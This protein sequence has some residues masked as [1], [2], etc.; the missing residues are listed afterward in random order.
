LLPLLAAEEATAAKAGKWAGKTLSQTNLGKKNEPEAPEKPSNIALPP[1][2]KERGKPLMRALALRR[3]TRQFREDELPL[4]NISD[5]LWAAFG[6]NRPD[7]KRTMPTAMNKQNMVIYAAMNSGIWRYLPQKHELELEVW[8]NLTSL[9]GEA[10]L[11]LGYAA[12]GRYGP[13]HAGSAYQNVGLYCASVGLG[14]VVKATGLEVMDQYIK[15][16][17]GY[18]LLIIQSVGWPG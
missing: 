9:L 16:P 7:G 3:S 15:P 8:Y 2:D 1:P 11:T 17:A 6:I 18:S 4:Q 13:M 10:P 12:E 5:M 14:N